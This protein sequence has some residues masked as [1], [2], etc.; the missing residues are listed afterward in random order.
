MTQNPALQSLQS[1]KSVRQ[2]TD[3]PISDTQLELLIATGQRAS[4]SSNLQCY[5]VVAVRDQAKKDKIAE[6]CGGQPQI[7][8][9]AVFLAIC[10]DLNRAKMITEARGYDLQTRHMEQFVITTIDAA[11][12]GQQVLSA[13]ESD[14]LGGCMIGGARNDPAGIADV[15]GLPKLVF[16][17]YGMTLGHPVPERNTELRPRLPISGILHQ[18][19]YDS[20]AMTVAHRD[21]DRTTIATGF[22]G[23][24]RVDLSKRLPGWTDTTPEGEYGWMEQAARRWI[25]PGATRAALRGFL[26]RQGFGFE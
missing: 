12:F 18:E 8:Q 6:L 24:R 16:V 2:F 10:A 21:Y 23:Q 13:A 14:G 3:E 15:L 19:R 9:C 7:A 1:H 20:E 11:L 4:T 25:D 22:Y 17:I 5:S 26:D